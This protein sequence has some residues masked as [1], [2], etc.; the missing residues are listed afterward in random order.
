MPPILV[1][2]DCI[3]IQAPASAID[4]LTA[5]Q[6]E[7]ATA[8]SSS[9]VVQ[10]GEVKKGY[11]A[12]FAFASRKVGATGIVVLIPLA[13]DPDLQ[14]IVLG[15][16][17]HP[18]FDWKPKPTDIK[19]G[20]ISEILKFKVSTATVLTVNLGSKTAISKFALMYFEN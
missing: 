15:T 1:C 17:S 3:A 6:V 2:P 16:T 13:G 11:T 9:T 18:D 10:Y 8:T 7:L 12:E 19:L 4:Y 20:A 14:N 5:A